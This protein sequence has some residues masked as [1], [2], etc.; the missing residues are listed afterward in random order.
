[1][2]NASRAYWF[3]SGT[4]NGL[5]FNNQPTGTYWMYKWYGDMAGDMVSVTPAGSQDGVASYDSSR[6]IVNVIFGGDSGNNSVQING[7]SA[8]GSAVKAVLSFTPSSGRLANVTAPTTISTST[9]TV[10]NGSV[11][12]PVTSQN[13]QGAYQILLTPAAGPVTSYQ[14][15]YEA[16]NA[17]VVNATTEA[18]SAASNGYFVGNINGS[19]DER[20]DSFVDFLVNVPAAGA[21]TMTIRY[22]NGG[23]ATSTQGLAYDGGAWTTVSY[24]TTGS[25][26][27]FKTITTTVTLK[28]GSNVIRLAKGAPNFAG[29]TGF[30]ELDSINLVQ[31]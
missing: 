11:T 29:G 10:T 27:S 16:E 7:L 24:P 1:M 15:T 13:A 31:S 12:V 25:W 4:V 6:K 17:T 3:E 30:A 18:S 22:A 2:L 20:S 8:L 9:L 23:T 21:Y 5:L 19:G 28:V 26:T 14:Q